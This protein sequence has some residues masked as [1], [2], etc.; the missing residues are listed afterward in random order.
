MNPAKKALIRTQQFVTDH[1]VALTVV[2]T[3]T[4]TAVVSKKVFGAAYRTAEQFISE[5]GLA[6]EFL[7]YVPNK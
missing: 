4:A 5:K 6:E 7:D 1:K 2:T 3:A